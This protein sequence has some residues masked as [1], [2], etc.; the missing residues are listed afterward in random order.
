[1][2][3]TN[4]SS[5]SS[6]LVSKCDKGLGSKSA[7]KPRDGGDEGGTMEEESVSVRVV[8]ALR[9]KASGAFILQIK[10]KVFVPRS[11]SVHKL[12]NKNKNVRL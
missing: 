3:W 1:M 4:G 8:D 7:P 9:F 2:V 10:K 6:V 12:K 5:S 11:A